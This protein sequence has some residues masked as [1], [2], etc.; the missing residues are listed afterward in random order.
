MGRVFYF[1]GIVCGLQ[2]STRRDQQETSTLSIAMSYH[3][4]PVRNT[5]SGG[6]S[7]SGSGESGSNVNVN[8][9]GL[10][11]FLNWAFG[12]AWGGPGWYNAGPGGAWWGGS[13]WNNWAGSWDRNGDWYDGNGNRV[14]SNDNFNRTINRD[15]EIDRLDRNEFQGDRDEFHG[16]REEF[17]GE[18]DALRGGGEH[19]HGGGRR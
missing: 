19:F 2:N 15:G 9:G 14:Y 4:N 10:G 12:W 6:E 17:R 13:W 3:S 7:D 18:R 5:H 1:L 11:G 8:L 16:D